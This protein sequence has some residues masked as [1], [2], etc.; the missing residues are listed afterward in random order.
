MRIHCLQHVPFEGLGSLE[1]W[2]RQ[3]RATVRLTRLF[4]GE[5]LPE[6][7]EYELLVVLGGPMGVQDET[8][9]PW[10][11]AEKAALRTGLAAGRRVLGIC[12]GAQLVAEVL[13]GRVSR[14]RER[15]IGWWPV[16]RTAAGLELAWAEALPQ[17]FTALHWHGD[18]FTLPPGAT[19]LFRSAACEQQGFAAGSQALGLQFHLESTPAGVDALMEHGPS[20][21]AP[22][23]FVQS[24]ER[25][26][27]ATAADYARMNGL[28]FMLLDAWWD[29]AS[30]PSGA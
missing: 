21:L 24:A 8:E 11:V 9:C 23:P 26:R 14:N 22:G 10:L 5:A 1:T 18:T 17:S 16:E 12:L 19:Q 28:L 20:D 2:A 3:R 15:E 7:L 29:G 27:A 6:P 13:G 4:A 30:G 25:L